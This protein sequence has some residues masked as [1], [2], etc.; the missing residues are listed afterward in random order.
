[1]KGAMQGTR[2]KPSLLIYVLA[3]F[4]AL[5]LIVG[6]TLVVTRS[7]SAANEPISSSPKSTSSGSTTAVHPSE[8][9]EEGEHW[10]DVNLADPR[11]EPVCP[12]GEYW[13]ELPEPGQCEPNP[14][15]TPDVGP[16][17]PPGQVKIIRDDEFVECSEPLQAVHQNFCEEGGDPDGT[18]DETY[19]LIKGQCTLVTPDVAKNMNEALF[20]Y[21]GCADT[22]TLAADGSCHPLDL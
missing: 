4:G 11:C 9:C 14:T 19:V 21:H 15:P 22:D 20:D 1:M 12:E 6:L 8:L 18:D 17:C 5:V 3:A 16:D 2:T 7:Q 10:N 13:T